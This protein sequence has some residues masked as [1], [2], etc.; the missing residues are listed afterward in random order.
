LEKKRQAEQQAELARK[1]AEMEKQ[2][3]K[4]QQEQ[5]NNLQLPSHV[6]WA[7]TQP[8]QVKQQS[9]D[10]KTILEQQALEQVKATA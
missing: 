2:K 8:Q 9:T 7:K 10:L 6:Q 4:L 1:Q 5:L 3:L